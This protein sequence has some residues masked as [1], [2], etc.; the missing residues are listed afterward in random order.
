MASKDID[1]SKL[2]EKL[3]AED[4]RRENG[5]HAL[6]NQKQLC[7]YLGWSRDRLL[8]FMADNGMKIF[9]SAY[10]CRVHIKE[11]VGFLFK[12]REIVTYGGERGKGEDGEFLKSRI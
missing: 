6:I 11:F 4:I 1:Y 10:D 3:M 2:T 5:G 7:G 9:G 8:R 12:T